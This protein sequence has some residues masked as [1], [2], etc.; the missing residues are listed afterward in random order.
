MLGCI[1]LWV[2]MAFVGMRSD[3]SASGGTHSDSPLLL[4]VLLLVVTLVRFVY[5]VLTDHQRYVER[6]VTALEAGE[7]HALAVVVGD[8]YGQ[9]DGSADDVPLHL[10]PAASGALCLVAAEGR[11][12]L[13]LEKPSDAVVV[14]DV[15]EGREG[16]L[17]WVPAHEPMAAVT[18]PAVLA[19]G[20]GRYVRG[21]TPDGGE[22]E[23]A[24]GVAVRAATG[25]R[26]TVWPVELPVLR[27]QSTA[28]P[29]KY[30]FAAAF[31]AAV[32]TLS[33]VLGD[34]HG[35][36]A[37]G[38]LLAAAVLTVIGLSTVRS[39][40]A[41]RVVRPPAYGVTGDSGGWPDEPPPPPPAP[42]PRSGTG[43]TSRGQRPT[44]EPEDK[45]PWFTPRDWS[46]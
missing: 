12:T 18:A 20:D 24:R 25:G 39:H 19:L 6:V 17:Y 42:R 27:A 4:S 31:V 9:A 46:S 40:H 41:N 45:D 14:S 2:F 28:R 13:F 33:G 8:R 32:L 37:G 26:Q 44:D 1:G 43:S 5:V 21:W 22:K 35:D 36:A 10:V 3:D 30:F 15:L 38:A 11:R 16:W 23:L 7:A 29:A 34:P